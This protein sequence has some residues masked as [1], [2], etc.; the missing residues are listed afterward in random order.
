MLTQQQ[1]LLRVTEI[2]YSLQGESCS[3]GI[4]TTFIRLT[5]CPLRCYYCDTAYAFTGGEKLSLA[6]ILEKVA[7][8]PTP[9]VTVTGGEPLA[10]KD[11]H[12]LL[13]QLCDNNYKVS[14]ETSGA[15]SVAKVDAR[16]VKVMDLKTP[17]S[18]ECDK[19]DYDNFNYLNPSD[20]IKFVIG[21]KADFDWSVRL[22]EEY[23]LAQKC[24]LLFSPIADVMSPT[25][26]ADWILEYR[27]PVRFQFQL[28]KYL[29]GNVAGK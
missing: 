19:N 26:L 18:Q 16:V 7:S 5:G 11:C 4:P 17:S 22:I 12:L 20:Q 1:T 10:Q 25:V 8:Y 28:H 15:L 9:Y 14:L 6:A 24:H 23:E 2:F 29:W 21:D 27:L 13:I 3:V